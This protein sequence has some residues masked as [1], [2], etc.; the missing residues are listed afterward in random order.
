LPFN[1]WLMINKFTVYNW[2]TWINLQKEN[3]DS[4]KVKSS[5]IKVAMM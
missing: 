5:N 2:L 3:G 1:S 4:A